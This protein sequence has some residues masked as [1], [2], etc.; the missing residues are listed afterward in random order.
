ML[1]NKFGLPQV[2]LGILVL[3][4]TTGKFYIFSP[5]LSLETASPALKLTENCYLN[6]DISFFL[7]D[8][9]LIIH[10][11]PSFLQTYCAWKTIL[12]I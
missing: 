3:A 10:W 11:V 8:R 7:K 4:P 2:Q 1:A 12:K 6:M 9:N 5:L